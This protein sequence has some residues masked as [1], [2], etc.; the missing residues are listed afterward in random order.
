M[1]ILCPLCGFGREMD[2]TKIPPRAQMATCPRCQHK[3]RF[4]VVD[5][6]EQYEAMPPAAAS[7]GVPGFGGAPASAP[8][9][10]AAP[11][12]QADAASN[13]G[14]DPLAA[15]RAAAAAQWKRLQGVTDDAG[16]AAG[17]GGERPSPVDGGPSGLGQ[18]AA[19]SSGAGAFA[20]TDAEGSGQ[21]S[22]VPFEELARHGFFGGLWG[23][24][25]RVVKTPASFFRSMP[26]SGGMAKPLI[27][28]LLLAE[29][30]VFCQFG[31]GFTSLGSM[32]QYAGS[33]E[34]LD[35]GL[36][37]AGAGS[38]MLLVVYPLL[39]VLRLMLMTGI[40]HLLLKLLRS[41]QGGAEGTFRVLCYAAA[42]LIVGVVPF[43][44]PVVGGLWSIVLT[45]IGLKE[46]HRTSLSTAL[47]AVLVP[48][49]MLVA[50]LLGLVQ[51]GVTAG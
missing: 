6:P 21:G 12:P 22:P 9:S 46:A 33:P 8:S 48:I 15:Q 44:G 13:S 49:M 1:R 35:M 5:D 32:S 29:F 4:R 47:F 17:A 26:V 19:S 14:P 40:I 38:L 7:S 41:G 31:W 30:M 28:H 51:A 11:G 10:G 3:F 18:G 20:A 45:V 43:V 34:L 25:T 50:A 37:L 24:I 2:E 16:P 42:P 36:S 27:F 39:L 23:T